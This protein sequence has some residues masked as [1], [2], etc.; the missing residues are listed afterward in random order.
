MRGFR[1]FLFQ[2]QGFAGNFTLA[3]QLADESVTKF[4]DFLHAYFIRAV[5]SRL[6][7][8]KDAAFDALD[9]AVRVDPSLGKAFLLSAQLAAEQGRGPSAQAD[10]QRAKEFSTPINS[11]IEQDFHECRCSHY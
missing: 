11:V 5:V 1:A 9:R 7:D 3:R 8:D 2:V 6:L 10:L 4:P